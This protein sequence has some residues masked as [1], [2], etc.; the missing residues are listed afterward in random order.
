M[1]RICQVTE[2]IEQMCLVVLLKH[3]NNKSNNN[4]QPKRKKNYMTGKSRKQKTNNSMQAE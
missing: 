3:N 4:N 1:K 2:K